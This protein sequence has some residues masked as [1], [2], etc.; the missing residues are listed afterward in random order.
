MIRSVISSYRFIT[1]LLAIG[2]LICMEG[3]ICSLPSHAEVF[4][5]NSPQPINKQESP[6][7]GA[8]GIVKSSEADKST[9]TGG[10][11]IM[12]GSGEFRHSWKLFPL[13]GFFNLNFTLQYA[14]NLQYI[15][16]YNDGFVQFPPSLNNMAFSSN[17]IF[18][19]VEYEDNN[20][21]GITC[22]TCPVYVNIFL[23]DDALVFKENGTNIF[24]PVGPIKHQLNK[25][26]DTYFLLNI[27][28]E[29]VYV[30]RSRSFPWPNMGN[31]YIR[32]AGEA[33]YIL[34]RNNN[35]LAFTYNAENKPTHIEDGLGRS[36]DFTYL[37]AGGGNDHHLESVTDGYG[38]TITFAYHLLPDDFMCYLTES[39]PLF[40]TVLASVTNPLGQITTFE[41]FNPGEKHWCNLLKKVNNPRS[42]SYIDQTWSKNTN[43][44]YAINTQQDAYGNQTGLTFATPSKDTMKVTFTQP[45]ASQRTFNHLR[46]RYPLSI[47]DETNKD[48]TF[49]YSSEEQLVTIT[50]RL[51]GQTILTYHGPTGKIASIK[52]ANNQ[53]TTFTYT[54]QTQTFANPNTPAETVAFTFFNITRTDY[55]DNTS[56]SFVYDGTGNQ[57]THTRQGGQ[58]W[59]YVYNS[60]GQVTRIT[61]PTGGQT[62]ATY[63][64]NGSLASIV[65]SDTGQITFGYDAYKRLSVIAYPG[66]HTQKFG[67]DQND[68]L[69]SFTDENNHVTTV[70]YDANGNQT[71]ITDSASQTITYA[72][73][74]M[75]R[76]TSLKN[77]LN[78][79]TT[80]AYNS[81]G[82]VNQVTDATGVSTTLDYNSRGWLTQTTIG[83]KTWETAYDDEGV[84]LSQTT[85]L[86]RKTLF[87]S[88]SL[89]SIS[90]IADPL[91]H[92]STINRD[93]LNRITS[94]TN[95]LG[96]VT[97]YGYDSRGLLTSVILP[98]GNSAAYQYNG[99]GLLSSITD[100]I[101]SKWQ[102]D[103][104]DTG[105]LKKMTDPLNRQ[106]GWGYDTRGRVNT[107]AFPNGDTAGITHDAVGNVTRIQYGED[108]DIQFTYDSQN[109]ITG[110]NDITLTRNAEGWVTSTTDSGIP[111]GAGYDAAG[112]VTSA[113]Y[114]NNAFTVTY[115]YSNETG[116]LT[117]VTDSLT[118]TQVTFTYD[119]DRRL[120]TQTYSNGE[121]IIYTWDGAGRLTRIKSGDHVDLRYM[122]DAAGKV[123]SLDMT[124][125]LSPETFLTPE[126]K[127]LTFDIASQISS[128]GF[129][130]DDRGR[131]ITS[132]GNVF[133]WDRASRLTGINGETLT[134]N[135]LG[136]LRTRTSGGVTTHAYYNY[137]LGL[138][139]IMAERDE[140]SGAFLRYYVWTPAGELLYMIDAANG[141]QVYFYHVDRTGSTLA[142]TDKD[143]EVTD[144]Y[145][146]DPHGRLLSHT[147]ANQQPFTYCGRWGVR[148]ADTTGALYHMRARYYDA[149]TGRFLTQDPIWP[150]ITDAKEV[151]PYLYVGNDPINRGDP[152]GMPGPEL[153]DSWSFGNDTFEM[154]DS[155]REELERSDLNN[156]RHQR[157]N[158]LQ[159]ELTTW[160]QE[161]NVLIREVQDYLLSPVG[162]NFFPDDDEL[163]SNREHD[164]TWNLSYWAIYMGAAENLNKERDSLM[165]QIRQVQRELEEDFWRQ[166]A[167]GLFGG[168]RPAP[169]RQKYAGPI[170]F[171]GVRETPNKVAGSVFKDMPNIKL[172][173]KDPSSWTLPD[174]RDY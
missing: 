133:T 14:P 73:N 71:G 102:F 137:A 53:T 171:F 100:L 1:L 94:V 159:A 59:T 31:Q 13:G 67:Y 64:P 119:E 165:R 66:G 154:T 63:N 50:D 80:L 105:F 149:T 129:G 82:R 152:T 11:P 91:N 6:P 3:L 37:T 87:T 112:R 108:P 92:T 166:A 28:S 65:D 155:A 9:L 76:V 136:E 104:S 123:T 27:L 34:D 78:N 142:L 10:D 89:G 47:T 97:Q 113:T 143:R 146:Y 49:T 79:I 131:Q 2:L 22:P 46:N 164:P 115:T 121:Q 84:V 32:R 173:W 114:T 93:A 19:L 160:Q 20:A 5:R 118:N 134:Y 15:S 130:Y 81:R 56:E 44:Q 174:D 23:A 7:D 116:L 55:P 124:A 12:A 52:N 140:S 39:N 26:G 54:S 29:R 45:D 8:P 86:G 77:R 88:N 96:L 16:P 51:G 4:S 127:T 107:L 169:A 101:G 147:G 158:N 120:T 157:L 62:N 24:D 70:A 139:P 161:N 38:R 68:R 98:T 99:L 36:L 141:K 48:S 106:W 33:I 25:V 168:S 43:G 126:T 72:Y 170:T 95:P 58:T 85:P 83:G 144:A 138:T 90:S 109:H 103:R 111:F 69:T 110:A 61:G 156:S 42:N 135:G 153:N 60:A 122:L 150:Q 117:G 21:T 57:L 163:H 41:Y 151:N 30:F 167:K 40:A 172:D 162:E 17:T 18:R 132:P 75:D 125:P 74:L 128:V 145:A 35:R 148:Q